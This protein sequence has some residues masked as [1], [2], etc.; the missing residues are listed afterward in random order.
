MIDSVYHI[1]GQEA[2]SCSGRTKH[3]S[4][5]AGFAAVCSVL[6]RALQAKA[7]WFYPVGATK[8]NSLAFCAPGF[9]NIRMFPEPGPRACP[10]SV[11]I[12]TAFSS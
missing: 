5:V 12:F 9:R 6:R 2:S 11:N 4:I 1:R 8:L 7:D 3:Y 10:H